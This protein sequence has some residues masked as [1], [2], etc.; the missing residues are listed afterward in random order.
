M[1]LTGMAL[2]ILLLLCCCICTCCRRRNRKKRRKK[3]RGKNGVGGGNTSPS[4]S[5]WSATDGKRLRGV[6]AT[7][8][9]TIDN[10]YADGESKSAGSGGEDNDD[11]AGM[12]KWV[13]GPGS[14]RNSGVGRSSFS[15]RRLSRNS[16]SS[17]K[18]PDQQRRLS[19]SES[20]SGVG[21][22]VSPTRST[23]K[24]EQQGHVTFRTPDTTAIRLDLDLDIDANAVDLAAA[25]GPVYVV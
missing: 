15:M 9:T 6:N 18:W 4:F 17:N 7:S 22:A 3:V 8:S 2:A 16:W 13:A 20:G 14:G 19:R 24:G 11:E 5:D 21:V 1:V 12:I 10:Y 23:A 25:A